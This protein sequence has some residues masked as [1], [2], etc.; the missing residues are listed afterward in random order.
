MKKTIIIIS[1][2]LVLAIAATAAILI[3]RKSPAT[4]LEKI[5]DAFEKSYDAAEKANADAIT[6]GESFKSSGSLEISADVS[7]LLKS[8]GLD[9]DLSA[10]LKLYM[11][12][13][14]AKFA[15]ELAVNVNGQKIIDALLA[16]NGKNIAVKSESIL[17]PE[18]YGITFADFFDKF[19]DS[20]FG[21]DG[22]Y[23]VGLSSDEIK[24][25]LSAGIRDTFE[26]TLDS[27]ELTA[28]LEAL[29]EKLTEEFKEV[30]YTSLE[31]NATFAEAD[32]MLTIA[33]VDVRTTDV[34]IIMTEDQTYKVI[35]DVLN[36]VK[37]SEEFKELF[38]ASYEINGAHTIDDSIGGNSVYDYLK[39]LSD[40]PEDAYNEFIGS[41]DELIS[42]I[43]AELEEISEN[44]VESSEET[45]G[46]NNS[47]TIS[48]N[49]SKDNGELIGIN[50]S[51]TSEENIIEMEVK[52]GPSSAD[53]DQISFTG[54]ND[55]LTDS[56][57]P[58]TVT[59][60]YVVNEDSDDCYKVSVN[61][62]N[63][64]YYDYDGEI[65]EEVDALEATLEWD[66]ED[67]DFKLILNATT[68]G[69][70]NKINLG[71]TYKPEDDK[72]TLTITSIGA[73]GITL[74]VGE[75]K[76]IVR[77]SD[78]APEIGEFTE[79]LDMSEAEVDEVIATFEEFEEYIG[80][81]MSQLLN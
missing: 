80:M 37:E 22:A 65:D 38:I 23:S 71:G 53:I 6:K 74:R 54:K 21:P 42:E 62:R 61:M 19:D 39:D 52:F 1:V 49:I 76:F 10:M 8:A 9:L 57:D 47:L 24:E 18:A 77:Y 69:E 79:V 78:T 81:F 70:T 12:A 13:K 48:F 60:E 27:V 34:S 3:F 51:I 75:I 5:E 30:L 55:D 40:T 2:V 50:L 58:D 59:L 44:E 46:E 64:E 63:V 41:I 68:E 4:P 20:V 72:S 26:L 14:N 15:D 36:F 16:G 25:Q 11:D 32:G 17:G 56:M 31:T 28:E 73:Q 66:K 35:L 33:G 67:Y 45:D 29:S 43:N 7:Q